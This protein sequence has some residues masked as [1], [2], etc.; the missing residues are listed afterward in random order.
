[1]NSMIE[2]T[3]VCDTSIDDIEKLYRTPEEVARVI[4]ILQEAEDQ[5]Y[6]KNIKRLREPNGLKKIVVRWKMRLRYGIHWSKPLYPFRLI[7]NYLIQYIYKIFGINR[8]VARGVEFGV[9]YKCNF[10]CSH[11]LCARIEESHNR[12]E[13]EPHEYAR[14]V[15]DAMKL[16]AV[17]FGME[18]GE[19]FVKKNWK[20]IVLAW[21]PK[22]N[23]VQI[24]SNGYLFDEEKAKKCAVLGVDSINFSLDSGIP[25]LHDVFRKKKGSFEKVMEAIRL[26]RKYKIKVIINTV[27]HRGNL[28]SD[29][30]LEL[31][32]FAEKEE[33]MVN[34]LFAKGVGGFKDKNGMLTEE[35]FDAFEKIVEPYN[36]W[37]VHHAGEMKS[38]HGGEGCP[39]LKEM[40]NMTPYGD[41]LTCANNHIYL[42]N[43]RDEPLKD[44]R[45]RGLKETP[46]GKYRQCFLAQDKDFMNIYYNLLEG[47]NHVSLTEFKKALREYERKH[48][49]KIYPEL[50]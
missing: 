5:A 9:T 48:K 16:G 7:R 34:L 18:G 30:F 1:M 11:C 36:Y 46:F 22:Y 3:T 49:K 4:R 50:E 24:S 25:E 29:G 40:I 8:H 45:E 47:K 13:L 38:S 2:K 33:L 15:K 26:C 12:M 17:T 19:P 41:V 28:Y 37:S 20:E 39:G 27:V 21:Q 35:D 43:V 31:L 14:I 23:H 44:I 10:H 6:K 32:E 42:G